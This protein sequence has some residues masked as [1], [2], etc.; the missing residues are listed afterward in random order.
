MKRMTLRACEV[1]ID[2]LLVCNHGS[3]L[4][5]ATVALLGLTLLGPTVPRAWAQAKSMT[6]S[7]SGTVID[8]TGA[9]VPQATVK[10]T[11]PE[12]GI[13]RQTTTGPV[14]EFSFALLPQG[15]YTLEVGAPGFMTTEQSGIVLTL[16]DTL[17]LEIKLTIGRIEQLTVY[18][19]VPLLQTQ[20]SNVSNDLA[21]KQIEELPLNLKN[22]L[23][24]VE[25]ESSVNDQNMKQ[26]LASGGGEDTA[27]QDLTFL[28]FGGGYFGT[29]LFLLNGGYDVEQGWGGILFVPAVDTVAEMK[30][31][32]YTFSAQYG[33]S[34]GNAVTMVTKSYIS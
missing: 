11:N 3:R 27:D 18:S 16:G 33:W 13:S 19:T 7:L 24:F 30:V 34:T 20:D 17:N 29:N 9:V 5:V 28:N 32:S 15:S 21:S 2:C 26:L 22:V 31:T 25:L 8:Q 4:A 6:A 23:G 12:N 14:G 1:L 10:L